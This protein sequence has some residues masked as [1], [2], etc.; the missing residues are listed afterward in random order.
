MSTTP[1]VPSTANPYMDQY[2]QAMQG[3]AGDQSAAI[4]GMGQGQANLLGLQTQQQQLVGNG[5]QGYTMQGGNDTSGSAWGNMQN[6]QSNP[7]SSPTPSAAPSIGSPP[8]ASGYPTYPNSAGIGN[9]IG[10]AAPSPTSFGA[11]ATMSTP[12]AVQM[13]SPQSTTPQATTTGFNPWSLQGE[14]N[15]VN[16]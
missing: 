8:V 2:A 6:P 10:S 15:S 16:P 13:T 3:F 1:A 7:W 5:G 14:S 11:P 12:Q 9:Q 4:S